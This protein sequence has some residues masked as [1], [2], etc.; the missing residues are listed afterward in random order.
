MF[1]T[2][3]KATMVQHTHQ[4]WADIVHQQTSK[5]TISVMKYHSLQNK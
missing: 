1:G 5:S 4:P 2:L 3:K